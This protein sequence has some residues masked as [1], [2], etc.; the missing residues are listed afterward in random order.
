MF[1]LAVGIVGLVA[2]LLCVFLDGVLDVFHF[3][4]F[5]TGLLSLTGLAGFAA[6]FGFTGYLCSSSGQGP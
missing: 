4:L 2:L 5:D 6:L 1:Y 3:D